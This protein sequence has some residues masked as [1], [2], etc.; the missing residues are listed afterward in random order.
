MLHFRSH[1]GSRRLV[2]EPSGRACSSLQLAR[3]PMVDGTLL[4]CRPAA[5]RR[6]DEGFATAGVFPRGGDGGLR[7]LR[8][9][10]HGEC[11][12]M[13]HRAEGQP[14]CVR[15]ALWATGSVSTSRT[16]ACMVGGNIDMFLVACF[17]AS[18]PGGNSG[19]FLAVEMVGFVIFVFVLMESVCVWAAAQQDSQCASG[20]HFGRRAPFSTSRTPACM[21]GGNIGMFLGACFWASVPG[22]NSG[23][24]AVVGFVL[25]VFVLM[26]SVCVWAAA[27]M[28]SQCASGVH[29]GRRAPLPLRALPLAWLAG[30]LT[31]SL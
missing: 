10:P 20:E 11:L 30:T 27:Q 26:E 5:C 17:W 23:R 8:V 24:G 31:C 22:G 21:V 3:A 6:R 19:R 4:E 7:P 1:F 29:F 12:R 2:L 13:G 14:V 16:P 15:R 28:D 18:M 9:R 25:F